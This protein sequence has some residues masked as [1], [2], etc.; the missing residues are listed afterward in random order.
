LGFVISRSAPERF[1]LVAGIQS[2]RATGVGGPV[3]D[4]FT[5]RERHERDDRACL[6]ADP[7]RGRR[8]VSR[9]SVIE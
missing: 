2:P 1:R 5:A 7:D 9:A 4:L 8:R 6:A 3:W